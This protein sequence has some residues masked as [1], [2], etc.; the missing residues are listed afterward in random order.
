LISVI[1]PV[2]NA[3]PVL[4]YSVRSVL[5]QT[6]SNFELWLIDDGSTDTSPDICDQLAGQDSRV[7]VVHQAN[8]G[9]SS[10][11]NAGLNRA[12]GELLAFMDNDDLIA[13]YTFARLY[14]AMAQTGADI[15]K[16]RWRYI[17]RSDFL[18]T[19]S[20]LPDLK[21]SKTDPL[22]FNDGLKQYQNNFSKISRLVRG[23]RAELRYFNEANW[24]KLYRRELFDGIE[25]P[26]GQIAQDL[27]VNSRIIARAS[28]IAAL[29]DQVYYW[30]QNPVSVSHTSD[31]FTFWH[32]S[33]LAGTH[34]FDFCLDQGIT[35]ARSYYAMLG[36]IVA[37]SK[38]ADAAEH[39]DQIAHDRQ[40]AGLQLRRL[41]P[42]QRL[43]CLVRYRIRLFENIIV[44]QTMKRLMHDDQNSLGSAKH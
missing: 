23:Q 3:E 33:F 32:D 44:D 12:N 27:F 39:T 35:P 11:Q 28:S 38:S 8:G 37:E 31:T 6:Y 24:G 43:A 26:V 19:Y 13:P 9:I 5:Q 22:I 4:A 10:A 18:K 42:G 36:S 30:V 1:M 29:P 7:K 17:G 20:S 21:P 2:Y 40:T 14:E 16:G 34:N 41:T 15:S 25:F